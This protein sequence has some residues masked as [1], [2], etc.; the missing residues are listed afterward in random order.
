MGSLK[1]GCC[2]C[3]SAGRCWLQCHGSL[4]PSVGLPPRSGSL[5]PPSSWT[6]VWLFQYWKLRHTTQA[7]AE[8]RR[9]QAKPRS[10]PSTRVAM[11]TTPTSWAHPGFRR[12][13]FIWRNGEGSEVARALWVSLPSA[14]WLQFSGQPLGSRFMD[15]RTLEALSIRPLGPLGW[16]HMFLDSLSPG[17]CSRGLLF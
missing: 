2:R 9:E 3:T 10:P 17:L 4:W 16:G 14:L 1:P 13:C 6:D 11:L 8:G 15:S 12:F 5:G 7:E